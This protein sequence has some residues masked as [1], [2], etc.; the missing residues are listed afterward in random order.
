MVGMID[1][2]IRVSPRGVT[3][4]NMNIRKL[5]VHCG[6][7]LSG[8]MLTMVCATALP[9]LAVHAETIAGFDPELFQDSQDAALGKNEGSGLQDGILA[10]PDTKPG[11]E[12][13][14]RPGIEPGTEPDAGSVTIRDLSLEEKIW[15]MFIVSPEALTGVSS[16]TMAG[17]AT[18]EAFDRCPVGGLIYMEPNLQSVDQ[19]TSMLSQVSQYSM[20][21]TGLPPFLCVDEEGGTVRR[22]SGRIAEAWIPDIPDMWS[23]GQN[24]D[25][26]GAE[27]LGTSIG[28]YLERL[29]FNVDFAPDA[30]VVPDPSA[31]AIGTRSFGPD[32]QTDADMVEAVVKGIQSRKVSATLKHFP[33]HGAADGDTHAGFVSSDK[34][35]DELRKEDLVPFQAGI[36]AGVRFVM[37]GHISY[38]NVTED[39]LPA[40][41]SKTFLTDVLREEMG[42][43]GLV[44]TD[45]LAMGAIVDSYGSADAAVM[46]VEAGADLIL[47]PADMQAAYD[48]VL[49][50]VKSG[51]ITEERIDESVSRIIELKKNMITGR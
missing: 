9:A 13:D 2:D 21:R 34:T 41:L 18:K 29:G 47:M 42:F 23:V 10:G 51:R 46:A 49:T 12:P 43:R 30:D 25:A 36:D 38:P 32:P 44:V 11:T 19:I 3:L 4:K 50:A 39:D 1:A 45:S 22:I 24:G 28:T 16:V 8:I 35:L 14:T 26:E 33:G 31:S 40:S 27:E 15:Q 37:A 17:P 48:G 7:A 6:S 20:E 5:I